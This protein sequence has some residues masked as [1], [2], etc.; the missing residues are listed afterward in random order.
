[1]SKYVYGIDLGTTYSCIAY[2]DETGRPVVV[3]NREGTNTTPSVVQFSEDSNEV[4]VGQVAKDTAV[5]Y[6]KNTLSLIKTKMGREST[7]VYGI[8]DDKTISPVE[9]S[10]CIL[11][12]ICR[13]AGELLDDDVKDVVI[14]CPAYF[15]EA[16]RTATKQ[17]GI[18]AGLHV[19]SILDEP[20][21]AAIYYGCSKCDSEKTL[22]VYDLGGG[23]FDVTV[24]QVRGGDINVICTDGDHDLGGKDWDAAVMRYVAEV[25]EE[26]TGFHGEYD[27]E[28]KQDLAIKVERAKMQLSSRDKTTLMLHVQGYK[29]IIELTREKFD[30]ITKPLLDTSIEITKKLIETAADYGVN[31]FDELL[32]VGGST[33]MPQVTEALQ[34]VLYMAPKVLEPDEAV[35]KGAAIYAIVKMMDDMESKYMEDGVEQLQAMEHADMLPSISIEPARKSK[36]VIHTKT[37]KSFGIKAL[38]NG[39]MIVSNIITKNEETP[40]T[41]SKIFGIAEDNQEFADIELFESA[42]LDEN[43]ELDMAYRVGNAVLELPPGLRAG[44][45]V[46]V[47]LELSSEGTISLTGRELSSN[48]EIIA[49]FKSDCVLEEEEMLE[50]RQK[51]RNLIIE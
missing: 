50:K 39:K 11:Q 10:A 40:C 18:L 26:K 8:H 38:R 24:M 34:E 47:T 29:A 31:K 44:S 46:E 23:T 48:R 13:D 16:E 15:G 37:T 36:V 45:G 17:A 43:Y 41:V 6:A 7:I 22:L 42:V 12:K 2:Q 49:T 4:V 1:M 35:A 3:Q 14:T 28:A 33:K 9:A 21:A 30:E 51:M 25:F 19:I 20:T 27:D 5:M 32:L